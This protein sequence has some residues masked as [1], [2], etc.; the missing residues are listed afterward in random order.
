MSDLLSLAD[1][2]VVVA[3]AGGGGIG[4]AIARILARAGIEGLPIIANRLLFLGEGRYAME[5]PYAEAN[6][7]SAAG[8]CKC[9]TVGLA[10]TGVCNILVGDGRSDFC[11]AETADFVFAK[12]ALLRHCQNEAIPHLAFSGFS[13]LTELL[14]GGAVLPVPRVALSDRP[15]VA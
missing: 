12:E 2:R 10:N 8:T 15:M 3:G 14:I 5:S 9:R 1:R 13:H 7:R 4:T 11:A 6:C